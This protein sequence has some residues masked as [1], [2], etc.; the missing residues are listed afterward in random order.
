MRLLYIDVSSE[1]VPAGSWR[2]VTWFAQGPKRLLQLWS[3]GSQEMMRLR[4]PELVSEQRRHTAM[5]IDYL[6]A[7]TCLQWRT[8]SVLNVSKPRRYWL[9]IYVKKM[10]YAECRLGM[11]SRTGTVKHGAL[12]LALALAR[13]D[14]R[15]RDRREQIGTVL[16]KQP[17]DKVLLARL[18]WALPAS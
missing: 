15:W 13:Y 4:A 17:R 9:W 3:R 16:S 5:S 7:L 2:S 14:A 1:V 6:R 11:A 10:G 18:F 12:A 8:P